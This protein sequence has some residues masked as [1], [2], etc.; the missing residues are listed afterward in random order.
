MQQNKSYLKESFLYNLIYSIFSF[1]N[2]NFKDSFVYSNISKTSGYLDK[3]FKESAVYGVFEMVFKFLNFMLD[4]TVGRG[5]FVKLLLES[6][7]SKFSLILGI[8]IVMISIIPDSK[9]NNLYIVIIMAMYMMIYIGGS[10]VEDIKTDLRSV[11]SS[12]Y[13]FIIMIIMAAIT[14]FFPM[15]SM[16]NTV[17]LVSAILISILISINVKNIEDI[18]KI[19]L[20]ILIA[21][22]LIGMYG[23]YSKFAGINIYISGNEDSSAGIRV[24]RMFSTMG[25]PNDFAEYLILSIPISIAYILN[26][27]GW[28]KKIFLSAM[29]VVPVFALVLSYSRSAWVG[30]VI[31]L[32]VFIIL[33]DW[34]FF[35]VMLI[36]AIA[37]LP[38]LP[39][40]VLARIK[41]IVN[42]SRDSSF[43]HRENIWTG[44][45]AMLS[46]HWFNGVGIGAESFV[47]IYRNFAKWIVNPNYSYAS[48]M[49]DFVYTNA[50]HSHNLFLEIWIEM[51]IF[52]IISFIIMLFKNLLNGFYALAKTKHKKYRLYLSSFIGTVVG[53]SFMGMVEY[54]WF[55][56][57][58]LLFFWIIIGL[59]TGMINI[60]IKEEICQ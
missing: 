9:W 15:S 40:T 21:A 35:P 18:K 49:K 27:D 19:S 60:V 16:K 24:G 38:F 43:S 59:F 58:I 7:K 52:G 26:V 53:I 44:A 8:S 2:G 14:S 31:S 47:G 39:N 34:R 22:F 36:L 33:Y 55:Y 3:A 10:K 30:L 11:H 1:L 12:L 37:F 20:Y 4:R 54:V 56:P 6:A 17:F 50:V 5:N 25:N 41:S 45:R 23:F 32:I 48:E 42:F 29:L 28:R 13:F 57:R 46:A 51:G